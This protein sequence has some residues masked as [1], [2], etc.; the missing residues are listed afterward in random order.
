MTA[1]EVS[2]TT[3]CSINLAAASST[4]I[5]AAY[6]DCAAASQA[7]NEMGGSTSSKPSSTAY[8]CCGVNGITCTNNY[9]TAIAWGSRYILGSLPTV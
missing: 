9:S 6:A 3:S 4:A 7:W 1:F 2:T 8:A 5:T